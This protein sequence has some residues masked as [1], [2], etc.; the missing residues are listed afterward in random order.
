MVFK[1]TA[2]APL[3]I[4][5]TLFAACSFNPL[6][7]RHVQP[8]PTIA[9]QNQAASTQQVEPLSSASFSLFQEGAGR[10][11]L[12]GRGDR[13]LRAVSVSGR[14]DKA[15][16]AFEGAD[17][18]LVRFSGN[19]VSSTPTVMIIDFTRAGDA[20][21]S[22]SV[23]VKYDATAIDSLT[24]N[25]MLDGQGFS[26][27]FAQNLVQVPTP[28]APPAANSSPAAT[29]AAAK[30]S[31]APVPLS[32][33][34]DQSPDQSPDQPSDQLPA[35]TQSA[36]ST[37]AIDLPGDRLIRPDINMSQQGGGVFNA[38][39]QATSLS[40]A[41]VTGRENGRVDLVLHFADAEQM[42]F[43]GSVE[44][45]EQQDAGTMAIRLLNSDK[46]SATGLVTVEYNADHSIHT[47]LGDG[48]LDSQ[49]FSIQF[50][51]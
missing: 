41:S 25:G 20:D 51:R 49:P 15:E 31:A 47:L 17:G 37:A 5:S 23:R 38:A 4:A 32:T 43:M 12:Q 24:G 9:Q 45:V 29:L 48:T 26:I 36:A 21:A 27:E 34:P 42:R 11:T 18:N 2:L 28:P 10:L 35:Q 44:Q 7:K 50:S 22:G 14:D 39:G 33:A 30:P 6:A 1:P 46:G 19:L 13:S 8:A 40:S 16:L 3:L